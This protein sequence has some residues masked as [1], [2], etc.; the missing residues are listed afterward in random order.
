MMT[1]SCFFV[2]FQS[3]LGNPVH[4][5]P[6]QAP[7]KETA[8]SKSSDFD[9]YRS[10]TR[11]SFSQASARFSIAHDDVNSDRRYGKQ[12]GLSMIELAG[13][14]PCH[15]YYQDERFALLYISGSAVKL[16]VSDLQKAFGAKAERLRSRAGKVFSHHVAAEQGVAWSDNGQEIAFIEIFEPTSFEAWK[17]QWYQEPGPFYK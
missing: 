8:I 13:D 14:A 3:C 7:I 11:L 5:K 2:L 15:L 4:S 1:F 17:A 12:A 9:H 6:I 10:F 16:S